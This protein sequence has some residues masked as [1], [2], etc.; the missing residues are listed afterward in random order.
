[1]VLWWKG[2]SSGGSGGRIG[3]VRVPMRSPGR[4]APDRAMQ[5]LFWA[6]VAQGL[7]SEDAG[8]AVGVSA[9]VGSRLFR[10]GGGMPT[11][12]M[13]APLGRYLSF[14][15]REEIAML[16]AQ[17]KGVREIA[18]TVGRDPGTI[19]RELRRNAAVRAG[20]V[21]KGLLRSR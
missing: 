19:S 2:K 4:P 14:A 15:E 17:K 7:S 12:I 18:R 3:G 1:V 16:R 8:V 10:H 20:V 5:R 21:Q 6:R 9:P 13:T 11:V